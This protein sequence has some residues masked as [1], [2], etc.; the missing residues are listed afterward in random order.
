MAGGREN[1]VLQIVSLDFLG[2]N[3]VGMRQGG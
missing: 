2:E 1:E 3:R